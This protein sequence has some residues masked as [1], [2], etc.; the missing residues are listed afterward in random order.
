MTLQIATVIGLRLSF[1]IKA[2]DGRIGTWR[3]MSIALR[4]GFG[5]QD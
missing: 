4:Q 2:F 3:I 5:E 1:D